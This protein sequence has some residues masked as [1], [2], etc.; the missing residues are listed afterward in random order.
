[1]LVHVHKRRTSAPQSRE[2]RLVAERRTS[3]RSG[4]TLFG[5]GLLAVAAVSMTL[6]CA[7]GGDPVASSPASTEV[8]T[9]GP[10]G[11]AKVVHDFEYYGA[12][13]NETVR[14]GRRAFYPVLPRQRRQIDP[15]NYPHDSDVSPSG[16]M[17]VAPPGAGDDIGTMIVYTDGMA[18]FESASGRVIW[19]TDDEQ[20]YNW[21]C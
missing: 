11:I 12:C 10:V 14:V 13:G 7:S 9:R 5:G 17:R 16:L 8:S 19:L 15:S 4:S 3:M 21:V 20:T 18:R 6:G 1:V 2:P